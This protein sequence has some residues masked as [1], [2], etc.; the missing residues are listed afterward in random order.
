[1]A[2]QLSGGLVHNQQFDYDDYGLSLDVF[3]ALDA[4]HTR[5]RAARSVLNA[6]AA[7]PGAY[8][9]SGAES[10]AGA[11]GK[12]A[13][14]V[15]LAGRNPRSFGGVNL[16]ARLQQRVHTAQDA[17]HGRATDQSQ[18]GDY[19]NTIGQT[20]VVR[21]LAG[22]GSSLA[23]EATRFLVKQQCSAGF[24]R[25]G[26]DSA[27]YT[28]DGGTAAQSGSSV[29]ATGFAVQALVAA[30][31]HGMRGLNGSIRKA[32][33]WLV[34]VQRS[35]GSF[36]GNGVANTNSTG[37]GATALA[38]TGRSVAAERAGAWVSRRQVTDVVAARSPRLTKEVGAIA[39][40][41]TQLSAARA[42][43]ITSDVRD[44]YQRATAQAAIGVNAVRKLR[45][46]APAGARH[47]RTRVAVSL[48]GLAPR[49]RWTL[50]LGTN[51]VDRGRATARGVASASF[52]LPGRVG[53]YDV[54][55]VGFSSARTG[56]DSVRVVR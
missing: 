14:A 36:G 46:V 31:S 32:S 1:L 41:S 53:R 10:Y 42:S 38:L 47:R 3:F 2:R 21:G 23:D 15:K 45:V 24:F 5:P 7:D 51:V 43:G 54:R 16:V 40:T 28:C 35:N 50:R 26:M 25:E 33:S 11:T 17:Q 29:D 55:A 34:R 9:G 37:L 27:D 39:Y 19:S 48:S 49:E 13:T 12:L 6:V 56:R 18:Y 4:L 30:R 52:R 8:V 44:Q 22:A 20:F